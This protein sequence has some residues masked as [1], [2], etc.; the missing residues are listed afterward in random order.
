MRIKSRIL[1]DMERMQAEKLLQPIKKSADKN[2]TLQVVEL[3]ND[4]REYDYLM[5]ELNKLGIEITEQKD[6]VYS[7]AEM[8]TALLLQIVP[9]SYCGYPQPEDGYLE[10]SFD[11][12]TGCKKCSYGRIQNRPLRLH[13]PRIGENDIFGVWWL[14][15]LVIT[16]KLK[17]I[18][19]QEKLT[20]CEIWPIIDHNKKTEFEDLYQLYISSELPTMS[21]KT[22]I[23]MNYDHKCDL[24]GRGECF[25]K[26]DKI[27]ERSSLKAVKDFNLSKEWFGSCLGIWQVP[28]VSQRVYRLFQEH[29]IKGVRFIPVTVVE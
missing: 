12:N 1:F 20:G 19:E 10:A 18:I 8:N 16:T 6:N 23:I 15:V 22:N 9:N 13:K 3:F 5:N 17:N 7:Q 21:S 25:M 26:G 4:T 24:C 14:T 29:D 11:I 27:Y 28:F 2:D